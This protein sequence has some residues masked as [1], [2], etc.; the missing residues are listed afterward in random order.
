MN[1]LLIIFSV[2]FFAFLSPSPPVCEKFENIRTSLASLIYIPIPSSILFQLARVP[3]ITVILG[4]PLE[5]G[6]KGKFT[7]Y[8]PFCIKMLWYKFFTHSNMCLQ[9]PEREQFGFFF[10]SRKM[11][12]AD[13]LLSFPPFY[14]RYWKIWLKCVK[15][16]YSL[17][18]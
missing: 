12:T 8:P 16:F 11:R 13:W 3:R 7:Q 10:L 4:G 17:L 15:R 18:K 1:N 2:K 14:T 5:K 9:K 6:E